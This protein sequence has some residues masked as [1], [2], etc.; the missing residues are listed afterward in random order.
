VDCLPPKIKASVGTT[1]IETPGTPVLDIP[2]SIAQ[3]KISI[4]STVDKENDESNP[5]IGQIKFNI[6]KS[7][8]NIIASKL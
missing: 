8:I 2:M 6:A 3:T 4:Q 7:K 5:F 1:S